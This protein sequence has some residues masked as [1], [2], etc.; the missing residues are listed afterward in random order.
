MRYSL[1][2][3]TAVI[4]ASAGLAVAQSESPGISWANIPDIQAFSRVRPN[5]AI[6]QNQNGEAVIQCGVA[7]TG[8]LRQCTVLSETPEG[9]GFGAA[10]LALSVYFKLNVPADMPLSQE[11]RIPI[12][13]NILGA[14][15]LEHDLIVTPIWL[16]AP[17]RAEVAAAY[18][19]GLKGDGRVLFECRVNGKGAINACRPIQ[20]DPRSGFVEPARALLP[21]FRM[22]TQVHGGQSIDGTRVF[23]PIQFLDPSSPDLALSPIGNRPIW[24]RTPDPG[25]ISF[26]PE[27]RA[28]GLRKGSAAID[29]AVAA[30]GG[31][32]VDCRVVRENPEDAGFGQA[33]L[34]G[35][36]HFALSLWSFD[37]RPVEGH[38]ITL[39]IDFVDDQPAPATGG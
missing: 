23:V 36:E 19:A 11:V 17:T 13:W 3:A 5:A 35:S 8:W 21:L 22:P 16:R 18:P 34:A 38:R 1:I 12:N 4:L 2:T 10:A 7:R 24:S 29:C 9:F 31:E 6:V 33:A 28:K 26:P 39:P 20:K 25:A 30:K 15:P 37:G 32:L 27:A 14:Q